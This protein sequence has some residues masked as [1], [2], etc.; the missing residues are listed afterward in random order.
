ME[1]LQQ[2]L[3]QQASKDFQNLK[4]VM[5]LLTQSGY[6]VPKGAHFQ[7]SPKGFRRIGELDLRDIYQSLLKDRAGGHAT[8]H[9][10][11]TEMRPEQTKP[12]EF[13]DPLNLNL[14][15]TLKHALARKPGVPLELRPE[16]FEIYEND[17]PTSSS[18]VLCLHMP[19]PLIC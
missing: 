19:C 2:I 4:Q 12:Y 3:G 11:I 14:V 15:A 17:Y 1:D 18:T 6:M 13:G 7:L 8:D 9:R 16:D 10:G 5:V